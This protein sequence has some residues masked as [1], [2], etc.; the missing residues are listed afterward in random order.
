MNK[1]DQTLHN[2]IHSSMISKKPFGLLKNPRLKLIDFFENK[3]VKVKGNALD[4]GAGS[5]YASIKLAL[6]SDVLKVYALDASEK[7]CHDLIPQNTEYFNL[8]EKVLPIC[9]S[10][11]DIPL[12]GCIDFA[13]SFGSL[14]HS[15]CLFS[16]F[17]AV[18][19]SLKEGSYL[20]A[21]EP[22]MPDFTTNLDYQKKY[23]CVEKKFG[24]EI[25]N[26]DRDDHFFRV[27]E[28]ITAAQF[29]GMDLLYSGEF[30]Y[31]QSKIRKIKEIFKQWGN[32]VEEDKISFHTRRVIPKVFVFRKHK[33]SIPIAHLW[34]PLRIG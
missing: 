26:G 9:A 23:N 20:L 6:K 2:H 21:Q 4:I 22:A 25:R 24:V 5:G 29:C 10:F 17:Q 19:N 30:Y 7:A 13:V 31:L 12:T 32:K 34:K 28:Y 15:N 33:K 18:S 16:S 11:S 3:F 14:H 8:T 27:S 1:V